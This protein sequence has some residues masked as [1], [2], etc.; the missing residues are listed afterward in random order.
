MQIHT[1]KLCRL[2]SSYIIQAPAKYS[3]Y[4][5]TVHTNIQLLS[6]PLLRGASQHLIRWRWCELVKLFY[7]ISVIVMYFTTPASPQAPVN[8]T[9]STF[10]PHLVTLAWSHRLPWS[11][12]LRLCQERPPLLAPSPSPP[13]SSH[14]HKLQLQACKQKLVNRTKQLANIGSS[15]PANCTFE[16]LQ[17]AWLNSIIVLASISH[18]FYSTLL[19]F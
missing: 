15:P 9:D 19:L 4:N 8:C 12:Y 10:L 2:P 1:C 11:H 7:K 14:I 13:T 3:S 16:T 18:L 5:L 17:D 6:N